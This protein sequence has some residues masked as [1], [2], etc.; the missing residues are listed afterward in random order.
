MSEWKEDA[1][2][3]R[4]FRQSRAE[5]EISKHK[6]K[7]KKCKTTKEEHKYKLISIS[8]WV[9]GGGEYWYKYKCACGKILYTFKRLE[10][11]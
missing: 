2:K 1:V 3:R 6:S 5:P 8:D 9:F 4:A 11:K 10:E 7:N